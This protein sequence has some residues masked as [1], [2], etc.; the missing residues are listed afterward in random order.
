M[1]TVDN[2]MGVVTKVIV[3]LCR[4]AQRS[5]ASRRSCP[6]ETLVTTTV[7]NHYVHVAAR[8]A[9][10]CRCRSRYDSDVDKA[11]ELLNEHRAR[12]IRACCAT[13]ARRGRAR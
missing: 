8:S 13:A 9:S 6:N 3:A 10:R 11:L 7:L 1:I 4:R 12:A 5:T 2:R